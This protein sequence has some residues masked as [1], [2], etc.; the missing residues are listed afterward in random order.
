M[1]EITGTP[2]ADLL[3]GS[4]GN[5]EIAAQVGDDNVLGFDGDDVIF[6]NAGNDVIGGNQGNDSTYGGRGN[7]ILLNGQGDD[8]GSGDEGIDL[9][10]GNKGADTLFGN[11]GDDAI[12]GGMDTDFL[13][14]GQGND[15][16]AGELGNDVISGDRGTDTLSGGAGNDLFVLSKG[17]GGTTPEEA[18]LILDFEVGD[19]IALTG[20]LRLPEINI[21]FVPNASNNGRG[22]VIIRDL[23]DSTGSFLAIFRNVEEG[24]ITRETLTASLDPLE[25]D[26]SGGDGGD[27]GGDGGDGGSDGGDGDNIPPFARAGTLN[28]TEDNF[29]TGF[30]DATDANDDQLT[31]SIIND[32]TLGQV[33]ISD[34]QSGF[35]V[36]TPNPNVSG[37]DTLTFLANDGTVDSNSATI[38]IDIF[39]VEDIPVANSITVATDFNNSIPITLPGFDGDGD[40]ITRRITDVSLGADDSSVIFTPPSGFQGQLFQ[41]ADGINPSTPITQN[42]TPVT[43][44][45]G[46]VIFVPPSGQFEPTSTSFEFIVS[47]GKADS[48]AATVTVN[49]GEVLSNTLPAIDLNGSGDGA[50]FSTVFNP[51]TPVE[52]TDAGL[53]ITDP[54]SPNLTSVTVQISNLLDVGAETLAATNS[55]EVTSNYDSG[56]GTLTLQAINGTAS[57]AAFETVLRTVSYNNT[58]ATP[59]RASRSITAIANDGFGSSAPVVSTV[60]YPPQPI[61]DIITVSIGAEGTLPVSALLENDLGVGLSI[62]AITP[63]TRVDPNPDNPP[64]TSIT[65]DNPANNTTFDYTVVDAFGNMGTATVTT[66]RSNQNPGNGNDTFLG[67]DGVDIWNGGNGNDDIS[68]GLGSDILIGGPGRDLLTGGAGAE[69]FVYEA[70]E[71]GSNPFVA[72]SE[73]SIQTKINQNRHDTIVDFTRGVD[74]IEFKDRVDGITNFANLNPTIQTGASVENNVLLPGQF[75]FAYELGDS[76]YLIYDENSNNINRTDSRILAKLEGVTGLGS[77]NANDFIFP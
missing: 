25:G 15:F 48:A 44:P 4:L 5:D 64:F 13:F 47:D 36:Y 61:A 51:G 41:T 65:I 19:R 8:L 38:T 76:T 18:D 20:G 11:G 69:I 1:A 17:G 35:F 7:D 46:I 42:N 60:N 12:F 67:T 26:G 62:V 58:S 28:T 49:I 68:G 30:F 37:Q 21:Q 33:T 66:L 52:I 43:N 22:D 63:A 55:T 10:F 14:G 27:G 73:M 50:N 40:P 23:G 54:D 3:F 77:L 29:V 24:V 39:P 75:L 34:P 53:T 6:G 9:I 74:R 31:F 56:S 16:L 45:Q 72:N 70:Q 32:P 71:D 57:L 2:I 59:N